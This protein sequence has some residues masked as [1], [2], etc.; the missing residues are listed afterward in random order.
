M[1]EPGHEPRAIT[2]QDVLS[3]PAPTPGFLCSL[4]ANTYG[5]EFLK[6]TIRDME[7]N[8]VVFD[9]ERERGDVPPPGSLSPEM[10]HA[11]RSIRYNFHRSF[12][13]YKTVGAKLVF[14]V[15]QQPL[16]NFRMVERHYFKDRLIKSF[17]FTF[18]FCIPNSTNSWEAIYDMPALSEEEK[19]DII[20]NPFATKSDSFYFVNDVLV[21]HNK[22]EYSYAKE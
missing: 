5:I 3:L 11:A 15:G 4:A 19:E 14:A 18:G 8:T 17:D 13:D 9:V 10:E 22:A 20:A 1:T 21:M 2:P 6:F 7:T 12:L 16:P